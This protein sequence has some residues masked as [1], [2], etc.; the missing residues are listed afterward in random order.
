MQSI[1]RTVIWLVSTGLLLYQI[2][3]AGTLLEYQRAY[4]VQTAPVIVEDG[5]GSKI[6]AKEW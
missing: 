2:I 6:Y 4:V 3:K 1:L 5:Y